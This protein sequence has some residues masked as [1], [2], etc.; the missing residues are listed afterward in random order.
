MTKREH[1]FK[2]Y[3]S[4]IDLLFRAE[5]EKKHF[6]SKRLL[7]KD[8]KTFIMIIHYIVEESIFVAIVCKL[9]EQQKS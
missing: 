7:I 6:S 2:G 5:E 1:A 3:T 9:L 4:T 8:F